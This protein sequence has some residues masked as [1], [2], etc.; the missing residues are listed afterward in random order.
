MIILR[1]FAL[2]SNRY[3]HERKTKNGYIPMFDTDFC[4]AQE[5]QKSADEKKSNK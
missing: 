2:K 4:T 5:R 3:A 1:T